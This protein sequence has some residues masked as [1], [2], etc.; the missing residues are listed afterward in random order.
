MIIF[1]GMFSYVVLEIL[2]D[3]WNCKYI[4]VVD[5]WLLGVVFY[6]CLCG[7]FLFL[8]E[9]ISVVF[10]YLLFEQ[11][12]KGKF[13]YLLFYWDLVGDFVCKQLFF[14]IINSWIGWINNCVVDFI[15]FMLVVNLEK[16]F[17]VD[18]CLVYFW[19]I[20]K[21]FG[22]NDSINGFVSGIQGL[23][24]MCCGVQREWILLVL[25]NIV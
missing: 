5:I 12:R 16:C 4:K 23:D 25:I 11:I 3:I 9:F 15:D 19:M 21:I 24:V 10:L 18:Q 14:C 20:M 22:V 13:D 6:I 1:C 7:F 8:D 17:I 2:V